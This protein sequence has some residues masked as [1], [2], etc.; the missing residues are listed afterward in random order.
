MKAWASPT[1]AALLA[2]AFAGA[3]CANAPQ[4]ASTNESRSR[5]ILIDDEDILPS[6]EIENYLD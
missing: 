4:E 5:E 6:G 2:G 3:V 1:V